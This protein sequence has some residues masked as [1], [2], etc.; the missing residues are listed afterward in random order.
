LS[1]KNKKKYEGLIKGRVNYVPLIKGGF[2]VQK[3]AGGGA[4]G[5][6]KAGKGAAGGGD[7][8]N[9]KGEYQMGNISAKKATSGISCQYLFHTIEL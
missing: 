8:S 2:C 3:K 6:D 7:K 1:E 9:K 5:G 4:K